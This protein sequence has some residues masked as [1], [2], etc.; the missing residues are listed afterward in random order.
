MDDVINKAIRE[1]ESYGKSR[2]PE[3]RDSIR[4][5]LRS[6]RTFIDSVLKA[7]QT[8]EVGFVVL[9]PHNGKIKAMVGGR[10]YRTFTR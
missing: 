6:S 9:D 7:A 5:E 2:N 4:T 8:I 3:M 10:N 1:D